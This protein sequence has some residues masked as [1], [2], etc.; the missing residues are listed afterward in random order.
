MSL[1]SDESQQLSGPTGTASV[2]SHNAVQKAGADASGLAQALAAKRAAGPSGL[3]TISGSPASAAA[4][5]SRPPLATVPKSV[6]ASITTPGAAAAA[7][8]PSAS[9]SAASAT[10]NGAGERITFEFSVPR[11]INGGLSSL[12]SNAKNTEATYDLTHF[13]GGQIKPGQKVLIDHVEIY[14]GTV[15]SNARIGVKI[16]RLPGAV[17]EALPGGKVANYHHFELSPIGTQMQARTIF[18]ASQHPLNDSKVSLEHVDRYGSSVMTTPEQLLS[19]VGAPDPEG[20]VAVFEGHEIAKALDKPGKNGQGTHAADL[21]VEPKKQATHGPRAGQKY[22]L[23]SQEMAVSKAR[24]IAGT[25]LQSDT[26]S[27]RLTTLDSL[28]FK[29]VPLGE[30]QSFYQPELAGEPDHVS[31]RE[32]SRA[33]QTNIKGRM[34]VYVPPQ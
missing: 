31:V 22:Y 21:G 17:P 19:T 8:A 20:K 10:G 33:L 12:E 23:I 32:H 14:A 25:V 6:G 24:M 2:G 26:F 9:S 27:K 29:L 7:A 5:A 1:I 13:T 30:H 4:T 15:T 16:D 18:S 34:T 28:T 3:S 11:T